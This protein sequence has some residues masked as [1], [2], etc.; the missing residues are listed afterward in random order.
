MPRL[1]CHTLVKP[2][3]MGRRTQCH[4]INMYMMDSG[5]VSITLGYG[6]DVKTRR[7]VVLF[8]DAKDPRVGRIHD[9]IDD[10]VSFDAVPIYIRPWLGGNLGWC[11]TLKHPTRRSDA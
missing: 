6:E 3:D 1:Q 8:V 5:N 2:G 10:F 9:R 7:Y 4:T 11:A